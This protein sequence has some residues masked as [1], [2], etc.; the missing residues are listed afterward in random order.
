M[1]THPAELVLQPRA[2]VLSANAETQVLKSST[3]ETRLTFLNSTSETS[4]QL[5]PKYVMSFSNEDFILLHNSDVMAQFRQNP[6][7]PQRRDVILQGTTITSNV[8][9]IAPSTKGIILQD[10]NIY[11][12]NQYAG[13][14]VANAA[15]L[16]Q[17]P[18]RNFRH[19][20][21]A[22]VY[23]GGNTEWMRIQE[24]EYGIPQVGIGTSVMGNTDALTIK[25]NT[26][27]EG[28]LYISGNIDM[29][30]T[31]F[32]L[33]DPATQRLPFTLLPEKVPILNQENK[34]DVSLLPQSFNFQYLKAQKNVGI[35]TRYPVQKLHVWGSSVVSERFGVGTT[36]PMS[37]VHIKETASPIPA[38]MIEARGGGDAAR[39]FV[40]NETTPSF[41]IVGTHNGV[42]VG[43]SSVN[44]SHKLTV[45]GDV[46]VHGTMICDSIEYDDRVIAANIEVRN[47]RDGII[48]KSELVTDNT[49]VQYPHVYGRYRF[50]F[51][52]GLSTNTITTYSTGL[53]HFQNTS[54]EVDGDTILARQP[55]IRSDMRHKYDIQ[56]VADALDKIDTVRGYTY[57][58]GD[59][60]REAG[61]LAQEVLKVFPEAVSTANPERYA[62]RYDSI[63]ALLIESIHDLKARIRVLES[64]NGL[65]VTKL[66]V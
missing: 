50:D 31:Q 24:S 56:Q 9:L 5:L 25:G 36:A 61:V 29:G 8:Q 54:I 45:G 43:T 38:L 30:D 44:S 19:V 52:A 66:H 46:R 7:V 20:F 6:Q 12:G 15:V 22:A 28:N 1:T 4:P 58:L 13:F 14:G 26:R 55:L 49:G 21:Q 10:Y 17:L 41:L 57:H 34:L 35:G 48:F 42:G 60:R 51:E 65:V 16:H 62:V 32:L 39:V 59:G 33:K 64:Q 47:E 40:A 23:D 37:R 27:V 2:F 63:I 18:G 3:P 53:V 11:S